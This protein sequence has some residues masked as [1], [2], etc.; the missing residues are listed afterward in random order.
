MA[1]RGWQVARCSSSAV[2]TVRQQVATKQRSAREVAQQYLKNIAATEG[3]I[4][5]FISVDEEGALQQVGGGRPGGGEA[6]QGV[7]K[8]GGEPRAC[9]VMQVV[10]AS[11]WEKLES[12]VRQVPSRHVQKPNLS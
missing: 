1:G 9:V 2:Q 7:P 6:G 4:G 12:A 11:C 5:A 8:Q 10:C 3:K